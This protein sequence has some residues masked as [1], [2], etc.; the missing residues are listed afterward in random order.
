MKTRE[1][2]RIPVCTVTRTNIMAGCNKC[3]EFIERKIGDGLE[4]Y[5]RFV[6]RHP[7][8]ILLIMLLANG[9]LSLGMFRLN[10]VIDVQKVYAPLN[11][12]AIK[13][14]DKLAN[15]FP[16][17]SGS[18]FL[19]Y[20]MPDFGK[21]AEVIVKPLNGDILNATFLNQVK[22]L[23]DFLYTISSTDADG[24]PVNLQQICARSFGNCSID[25]DIFVGNEFIYAVTTGTPISYPSFMHST[26]GPVYY[27]QIV[28]NAQVNSGVLQSAS[29]LSLRVTL[30]TDSSYY[31]DTAKNWQNSFIDRMKEYSS[32]DFEIVFSTADSLSTELNDNVSGDIAFFSV[33]FT[34]MITYACFATMTARCDV[35]GQKQN[36]GYAGVIAAALAIASAFGLC[37]AVGVDFVSI[38]GVMPFLI[39]GIGVDDMFMLISGL[40]NSDFSS[41][42]EKRIGNTMRTSGVSITITSLTD[43]LAFA[44]GTS[45]VFLSVRNFCIF[46]GVAVVFCYINQVTIFAACITINENRTEQNR[47]YMTCRVLEKSSEDTNPDCYKFCCTGRK[48]KSTREA[49]SFLDKVPKWILPRLFAPVR[50]KIIILLLFCVYLAVSILGVTEMK[51]GL[52]LRNL[53]DPDSYYYKY[54]EWLDNNFPGGT[55]VSIVFPDKMTYSDFKIQSQINDLITTANSEDTVQNNFEINWLSSY[56]MYPTYDNSSEA[57]FVTGLWSFLADITNNRFRNDIIIDNS[58]LTIRSS[59][60]HFMSE[61]IKD[62]QDQ[63]NFML[64]MRDIADDSSLSVFM[65]SPAFIFYEQYV[66]V[67]SQTLQTMGIAVAMVFFVTFIFMPHPLLLVY[68]SVAVAMITVGIFGFLPF[69]GLTLSSI[70]MIHIIMSIGFS[71]DF[72]AHICHGYMIS[73]GESRNERMRN[74]LNKAG[75]PIF[76]GA[77][78]SIL[79]VVMLAAAK[80]YV[81]FS[82]FKVMSIV[83]TFGIAHA[84]LLLPVI[85]SL[86]GPS[87]PKLKPEVPHKT[88]LEGQTGI[89]L[90]GVTNGALKVA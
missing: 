48:P 87:L 89:E 68:V 31:S 43:L 74:G 35:V 77:V 25:G 21:Q 57:N 64:T 82:F 33:T 39:I 58:S 20:Q 30:R 73:E 19:A 80:S 86:I 55:P 72:V 67:L 51:Q 32:N 60:I 65:F 2:F 45:S 29:M 52:D 53:V 49:E 1:D 38:V 27:E 63:G 61:S 70:T 22:T 69:L 24:K 7:V 11:S 4:T 81:F 54:R 15:T 28:G 17:T 10:Y 83:I 88:K 16:D 76:H 34:L 47:H 62:S 40:I 90:N 46:S 18:A 5:G 56:K 9:L 71:V 84:V 42:I 75:A 36:L 85:L 41:T 37:C 26:R 23:Y 6:A 13:D 78:S 14:S 44:A 79:G 8:K 12:Q 3:Y 59:R 66:V 50:G